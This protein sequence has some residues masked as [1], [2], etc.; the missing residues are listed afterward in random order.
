MQKSTVS[1]C[2]KFDFWNILWEV[3]A[4]NLSAWRKFNYGQASIAVADKSYGTLKNS[5]P[6]TQA[7][8]TFS[9]ALQ[10]PSP[11]I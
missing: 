6:L 9:P 2:S 7:H 5:K 4:S 10:A 11:H 8:I 1:F 3:P